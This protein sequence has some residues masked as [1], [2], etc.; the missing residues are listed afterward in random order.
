MRNT[1]VN[2]IVLSVILICMYS[3]TKEEITEVTQVNNYYN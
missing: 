2:P 3:F 1:K